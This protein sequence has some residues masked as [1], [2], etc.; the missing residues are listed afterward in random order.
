MLAFAS[1]EGRQLLEQVPGGLK[2]LA[3]DGSLCALNARARQLLGLGETED[4]TGRP[5]ET[6]VAASHRP[7]FRQWFRRALAGASEPLL[8]PL[9]GDDTAVRWLETHAQP[10]RDASGQVSGLVAFSMDAT[11][12][13]RAEE[14][15]R[16]RE[17]R[18][19]TTLQCIGDAV[20]VTDMGGRIE[21]LNAEAERLTGWKLDEARGRPVEE[22]FRI[23]HEQTRRPAE[24][25]VTRVLREGVVVGLANH[26][27]LLA[28]DGRELPIADSGAPIYDD[29]GRLTGTV[30]VFRDQIAERAAQAAVAEARALA[31][32]IVATVREP[33]LVLDAQLRVVQANRSF[34]QTFQVT[35]EATLGRPLYELGNRQWDIPE[36]HRLL[37]DIL[38]HNTCL[39]DFEVTHGFERLGQR[40]MRLNAR[41]LYREDGSPRLILLAIEDITERRH[42]E[43]QLLQAQKMEAI[44]RLAGGVAHDFNNLLA[45][46]LL[47]TELLERSSPAL[48]VRDGLR[49]IRAA[50]ERAANLT[51]QLL[52]FSRRQVLQP[53]DLDLNQVVEG[54]AKMLRRIIGEDIELELTLAPEPLALRADPG[55]IEQVV[56]NLV[57]NAR[58]AMPQGGRLRLHTGVSSVDETAVRNHPEARPGRHVWLRVED[59]GCG[60]P[61]EVLPHIFEPFFTTKEAGKGTGLG[62]ATVYGVTRQH[63]GWITVET[64]VG[65]GTAFQVFLPAAARPAQALPLAE[66]RGDL[67]Q[68]RNEW[69]LLVEDDAPL[70]EA[71][72]QILTN[73]G[74]RV[75]AAA[76][77]LQALQI[78]GDVG[79]QVA[80]VL[81]D[82]VMPG[83]ISGQDLIT[84]LRTNRPDL[85][86]VYTSGYSAA[87]SGQEIALKP[88][89]RFLLKPCPAAQLLQTLRQ[90][91][92]T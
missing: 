43:A 24:N 88:G 32:G 66:P 55:M 36:L 42:L 47:Q 89:E 25:P 92:D 79:R 62:L 54:L 80:L 60:I 74:Y 15:L 27:L 37:T 46:L 26:T 56:M 17:E 40:T 86:V 22:V 33:L 38:P 14:S 72:C 10:L 61:P 28:R 12:R 78:W 35:P 1:G 20:I 51:R 59:T 5:L 52:L 9:A 63:Q 19:R 85:K 73:H 45:V 8:Y 75:L 68:G 87:W 16:L 3:P 23:V 81:T 65:R 6:W 53:R 34:F 7:A 13:R 11:E 84:L 31:E 4:T 64:E 49:Q 39:E 41:R 77:S 69:I 30:L 67:P 48:P 2:V 57:V 71:T 18:W 91:L 76:D 44:G 29:A 90:S 82:L 70:R 21:Q 58:D 83:G 50:V